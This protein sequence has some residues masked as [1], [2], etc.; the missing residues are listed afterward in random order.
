MKLKSNKQK[1]KKKNEIRYHNVEIRKGNGK[2][3]NIK[4][5]TY[6][7]LEK[8]N[9]YIY[10]VITHS[11]KVKDYLVVKLRKNPNPKDKRDSY[12]VVKIYEDVKERFEK[13]KRG[14]GIDPEDEQDIRDE[15]KK[16]P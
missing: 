2:T 7:F 10:V 11:N 16:E 5:P 12:R 1:A 14:W 4:H 6:V 8:G 3:I 13:S 9:S 15:Y